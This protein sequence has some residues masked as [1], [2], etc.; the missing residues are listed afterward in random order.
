[1]SVPVHTTPVAELGSERYF[2]GT[3]SSVDYTFTEI[4]E[5]GPVS[6]SF[7]KPNGKC[8][9]IFPQLDGAQVYITNEMFIVMGQFISNL[10]FFVYL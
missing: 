4:Q 7:L 2:S 6:T 10:N 9:F 5:I 3:L 8:E 1:M